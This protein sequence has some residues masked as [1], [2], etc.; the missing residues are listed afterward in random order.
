[1]GGMFMS[2]MWQNYVRQRIKFK[3]PRQC[4]KMICLKQVGFENS[5]LGFF[6]ACE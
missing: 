6:E 5:G 2:K 3:C 1:M 4:R